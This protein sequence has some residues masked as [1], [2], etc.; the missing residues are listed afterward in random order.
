MPSN[1]DRII[2]ELYNQYDK[3]EEK[4]VEIHECYCERAGKIIATILL[5]T[6]LKNYY[7]NMLMYEIKHGEQDDPSRIRN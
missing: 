7:Y 3:L 6:V 5:K 1:I 2:D 4:I